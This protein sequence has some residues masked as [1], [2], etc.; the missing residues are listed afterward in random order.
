MY[1]VIAEVKEAYMSKL[2]EKIAR[3][4]GTNSKGA[5]KAVRECKLGNKINHRKTKTM[6]L[7]LP[8]GQRQGE[9]GRLPPPLHQNL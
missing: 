3:L 7:K 2:A 6:A 5:W 9:H 1:I 4:A 8:N